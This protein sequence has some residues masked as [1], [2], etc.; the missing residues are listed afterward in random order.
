MKH[1]KRYVVLTILLLIVFL[2]K[3]QVMRVDTGRIQEFRGGNL[4][5]DA[6]YPLLAEDVN[7]KLLT[8]IIDNKEYTNE[9]YLF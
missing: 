9:K 6:W 3:F 2:F 7:G 1:S 5:K 8:L 4:E